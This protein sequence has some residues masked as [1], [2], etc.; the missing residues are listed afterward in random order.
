[1]SGKNGRF[2]R[3]YALWCGRTVSRFVDPWVQRLAY[4]GSFRRGLPTLGDLDILI[5][6]RKGVRESQINREFARVCINRKLESF[7][8]GLSIG[9]VSPE[10][11]LDA[12]PINLFF[13]R[14][15]EWGAALLYS[16]GSRDYNIGYRSFAK[17]HYGL[18]VNQYG[19]F[20]KG[21]LLPDSGY[22]ER[23]VTR[24]IHIPWLPPQDRTDRRLFPR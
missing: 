24:A 14:E 23:A 10:S 20:R 21:K 4:V 6:P 16:T 12:V 3:E 7:G 2:D 13:T 8:S 9:L 17:K 5:I 19:V 1:L 18:T 22:S 11:G 15:E